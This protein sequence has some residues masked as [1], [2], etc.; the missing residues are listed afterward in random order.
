MKAQKLIPIK[1]ND[2]EAYID[3]NFTIGFGEKKTTI[4]SLLSEAYPEC[5][6]D[7]SEIREWIAGRF[8]IRCE[9]R[10]RN[11]CFLYSVK[12]SVFYG[13]QKEAAF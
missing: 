4:E 6:V 11:K 3:K 7:F 13:F 8:E 10:E 5:N 2:I 1:I 9:S 12:A